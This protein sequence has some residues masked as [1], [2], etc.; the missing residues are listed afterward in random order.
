MESNSWGPL[1]R[2]LVV[3]GALGGIGV[4]LFSW[5]ALA[6]GDDAAPT[7]E[8][9]ELIEIAVAQARRHSRTTTAIGTVV[10]ARSITLRNEVPGT[11]AR[12]A[13]VPG[14]IVN[15][16]DVL[17]ALDVSLER[18]ELAAFE[19]QA[20]LAQARVARFDSLSAASAVSKMDVE[21]ARAESEMALAQV[22]RVQALIARKT[23]RAPFRAR[24]GITNLNVGQ[25]LAEG[26]LLTTLQSVEEKPFIDFRVA[27]AAAID[28]EPGAEV[29]VSTGPHAALEARVLAMDP[30]VDAS[31][32]SVTVRAQLSGPARLRPGSAVNVSLPVARPSDVAAI[33]RSAVRRGPEGDFVFVIREDAKGAL[34]A[35]PRRVIVEMTTDDAALVSEGLAPGDRVAAAGSFKLR[36]AILVTTSAG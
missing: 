32:R 10:A 1:R 34:R 8:P 21:T 19:A 2:S 24:V 30:L 20:R 5:K 14:A 13:I 17:I 33:P 4:V 3:L 12:V 9:S 31:S 22:Q 23:L 27:Q 35:Y 7:A 28:L 15:T 16:G 18:A 26:Q 25:Y 11:V 6:N 36:D 29:S